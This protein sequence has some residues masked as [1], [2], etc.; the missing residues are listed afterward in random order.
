[1]N[2]KTWEFCFRYGLVSVKAGTT[3][4]V[5]ILCYYILLV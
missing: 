1:M 5:K 2:E 3:E 4:V